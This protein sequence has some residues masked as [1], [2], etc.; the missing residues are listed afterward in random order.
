M[1]SVM[2]T[3]STNGLTAVYMLV[4]GK[5]VNKMVGDSS[6]LERTT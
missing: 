4:L 3:E 5:M 1:A 6:R 2:A